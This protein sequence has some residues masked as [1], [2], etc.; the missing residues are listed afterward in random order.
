MAKLK[1][2][3]RV[4]G[5]I[6]IDGGIIGIGS[7]STPFIVDSTGKVGINTTSISANLTV[8]GNAI[9]T[10]ITTSIHLD[11]KPINTLSG[12]ILAYAYYMAMP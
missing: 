7:G 3:T 10:G 9:I 2:G 4:Y 8:D 11:G 12:S 1:D 5:D 6:K